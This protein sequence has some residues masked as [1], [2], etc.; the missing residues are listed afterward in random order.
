MTNIKTIDIELAIL[1]KFKYQ[2]NY[3]VPN[4]TNQMNLLR[5]ECDML[6]ISKSGFATGFEIKVSKGDLKADLKKQ[7]F[8]NEKYYKKFKS[9]Y[10]AV[11]KELEEIALEIIPDFCGLYVFEVLKNKYSFKEVKKSIKISA[12]KW[13]ENEIFEV[14]RLGTMRI[15]SLKNK[16]REISQKKF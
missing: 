16:I 7:H 12:Y 3:I 14:L 13:P 6:V 10:Y 9:F 5:F 11:P 2:Q 15:F 4:I 8:G 1:K